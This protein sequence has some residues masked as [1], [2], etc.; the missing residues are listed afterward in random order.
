MAMD[1]DACIALVARTWTPRQQLHP[2]NVAWHGSGCDGAPPADEF[3][4]GDGW[5]AEVWHQGDASEVE[6]H[7]A[8]DLSPVERRLAFDVVCTHVPRGSVNLTRDAPMADTVRACGARETKAPYFLLQR[9]ILD[10]WPR[11]TLPPGYTIVTAEQ[12]G[13]RA[14]VD[15]HRLAWA[16]A[17][18]KDLLG[19][20]LNGNEGQSSFTVEKYEATKAVPIYRPELDLV[21]IA[22]DGSPA[23]FALGWHDPRSQSMLFEPVGTIPEHARRGLARA[24]CIAVMTAAQRL[25]ATQ[26][27]VGPRGDDAYPAPRRLYQSLGFSTVARTCTLAWDVSQKNKDNDATRSRSD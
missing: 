17:R 13:E 23:A 21:V 7:F 10:E 12:A 5:F 24:V 14:R 26:A 22:P 11:P 16:P 3:L 19:L 18:I 15:A 8:P 9:R 2:G 6:G 25:G 4:D 1:L 20:T 27:V